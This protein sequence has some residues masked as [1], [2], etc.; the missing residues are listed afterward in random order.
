[1]H[2]NPQL[3]LEEGDWGIAGLAGKT[4]PQLIV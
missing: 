1:M 2:I 3:S 4:L